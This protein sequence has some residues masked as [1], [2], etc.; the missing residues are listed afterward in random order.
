MWR[1]LAREFLKTHFDGEPEFGEGTVFPRSPL[2][3]EG[4]VVIFPFKAAKGGQRVES[5]FVAV[6]ET[7]P[8]YYPAYELNPEQAFCLHL[9][10]RFMLVMGV[11]SVQV[12][13]EDG[14]D[15][16]RNAA[17]IVSRVLPESRIEAAQVAAMFD[18][19]G[20][21]HA[22]LRATLEDKEVYIMGRDAPWGFSDRTDL[23]AP[24]A[25]RLHLGHVLLVEPDPEQPLPPAAHEPPIDAKKP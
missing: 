7:E 5:Y 22:V 24:V 18:V 19:N 1:V 12:T 2:A 14:Y 23:P 13:P 16:V 8:N 21:M 6:G 15:P 4:A 11:A 9:G 17:E 25:Y 20:E 10:T 3:D